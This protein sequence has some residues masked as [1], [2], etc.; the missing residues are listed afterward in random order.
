MYQNKLKFVVVRPKS[1][2][3]LYVWTQRDLSSHICQGEWWI[4]ILFGLV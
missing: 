4:L 3:R 2:P 1:G